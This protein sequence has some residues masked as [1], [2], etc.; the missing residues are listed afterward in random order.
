M[1]VQ[2][3]DNFTNI[4]DESTDKDPNLLAALQFLRFSN[5]FSHSVAR[6][7]SQR[8]FGRQ[9]SPKDFDLAQEVQWK[10]QVKDF[11]LAWRPGDF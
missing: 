2:F 3:L 7:H 11:L 5:Y 1:K 4:L 9:K 8:S 6:E 10:Y